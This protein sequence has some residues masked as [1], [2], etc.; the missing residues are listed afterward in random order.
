MAH[1]SFLIGRS[2]I[3]HIVKI[4]N[5]TFNYVN[6]RNGHGYTEGEEWSKRIS[7][8]PKKSKKRSH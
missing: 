1:S 4:D 6:Q 3:C 5:Q 7:D 2:M 8:S